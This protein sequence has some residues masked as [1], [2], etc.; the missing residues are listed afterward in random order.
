MTLNSGLTI[1][2]PN[3][4][5]FSAPPPPSDV[6]L[7]V[8]SAT[9]IRVEWAAGVSGVTGYEITFEPV[10]GTC[11]DIV[12]GDMLLESGG[13]TSHTLRGLEEFVEYNI[14]VRSRGEEAVGVSSPPIHAKTRAAG[15]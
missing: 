9:S 8:V 5:F 6:M 13:T 11:D 7:T 15:M 10:E 12:G 4:P 14:A 2:H 1:L 3:C